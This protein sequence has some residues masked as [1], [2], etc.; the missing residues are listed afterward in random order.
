MSRKEYFDELSER[1]DTIIDLPRVRS[2]LRSGL[3]AMG[4]D[5]DEK[6]IDIGCG[7]GNLSICLLELLGTNGRI[8]AVDLS[9]LMLAQA[10]GKIPDSRVAFHET[11]ADSLPLKTGSVDRVICF[12]TWP[13]ITNPNETLA[14]FSRVL[15]HTGQLYV[16]HIDSRETINDIH[17]NAGEAVRS[18]LLPPA[19]ELAALIEEH[20]FVVKTV[21]DNNVEYIIA[22]ERS[23]G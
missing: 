22:A 23:D 3:A 21:I 13:H 11:A 15:R 16:W 14:E 4:I 7:T 9:P 10:R 17:R 5:S 1:W 12:S 19:S 20:D 18:D 6:I 8:H 2:R